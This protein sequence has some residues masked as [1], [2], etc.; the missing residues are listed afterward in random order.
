MEQKS[1]LRFCEDEIILAQGCTKR[2]M[3]KIISGKAAVYFHYGMPE[4][5]LVGVLSEQRC[6]GELSILCGK[7][8]VYT[9]V[10]LEEV[11][12]MRVT[13]SNFD[14]FI[15]NNT[16]NAI[17]IMKNLAN[18][19]DTLS[20]NLNMV[21]DDLTTISNEKNNP[22]KMEDITRQIREYAAM[23]SINKTL[24]SVLV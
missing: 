2:E 8:S 23:D 15:K 22:Q 21:N 13:E 20:L 5:Y 19:V 24:F 16:H 17:G 6:F 14:D 10:A 9:V 18:M 3:Y 1:M 11:L 12:V 7:P 4:E